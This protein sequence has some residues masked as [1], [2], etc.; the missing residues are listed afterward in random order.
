MLARR[1]KSG[2]CEGYK[3]QK[4][5]LVVKKNGKTYKD[6]IC[7]ECGKGHWHRENMCI[8][9]RNIEQVRRHGKQYIKLKDSAGEIRRKVLLAEHRKRIFREVEAIEA[10]GLS[11]SNSTIE[12]IEAAGVELEEFD[13]D[14]FVEGLLDE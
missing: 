1:V 4:T 13:A 6:R 14:K 9:C 7:P 3:Y 10:A 11:P 12:E 2:R 8:S 5:G